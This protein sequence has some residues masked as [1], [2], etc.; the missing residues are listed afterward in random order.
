MHEFVGGE[1]KVEVEDEKALV[2]E[3]QASCEEGASSSTLTF[4]R[5]FSLPSQADV[6]AITSALSSDGVLTI[7]TPKLQQEELPV[8]RRRAVESHSRLKE[9]SAT[10]DVWKGEQVSQEVSESKRCYSEAYS[11]SSSSSCNSNSTT[12]SSNS[13]SRN[14]SCTQQSHNVF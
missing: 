7:L 3:G 12:T 10:A 9:H 2:V 4:R 1:L 14:S 11:S 8:T 13:N 6:A 5:V